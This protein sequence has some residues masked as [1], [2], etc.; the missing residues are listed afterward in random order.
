M[1]YIINDGELYH[2]GVKGMK[3]GKRKGNYRS[4]GLRSAIARRSNEK[5]DA[6]FDRWKE[7]AKRKSTAIDLGKKANAAK[8]AYDANRS[9]KNLKSEYKKAN[10]EYKKALSKNTTWHKGDV[11][12]EVGAD[13]ARKYL[14]AAK[15]IK[16]SLDADPTNKELKKQYNDLM[17][18]HAVERANARRASK[19]GVN[20]SRAKASIKRTMTIAVSS[21]AGTAAVTAGAYAANRYLKSHDVRLNGRPV[22]IDA[23][24]IRKAADFGK[25]IVGLGK[26]I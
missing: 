21:L 1:N 19:T 11:K 15:K 14:S 5:V 22:R 20:R 23:A 8:S 17:S 2:F 25:K 18:K 13:R 7:N 3:W 10:K 12:Y 4:T 24:N 26:F 16:K 6:G 9:D